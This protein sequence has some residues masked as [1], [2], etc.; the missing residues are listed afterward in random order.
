MSANPPLFSPKDQD[1]RPR[2]SA[3]VETM[4]EM[5]LHTDPQAMSRAYGTR[6]RKIFPTDRFISLSR[7][8]LY[9]PYFRITRFSGWKDEINPWYEKERLPLLSGGLLAELIY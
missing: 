7:R 8:D 4:R 1:W 5:S 2:L 3:I 6:I 9:S